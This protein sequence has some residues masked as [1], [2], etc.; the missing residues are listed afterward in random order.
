[1]EE[2]GQLGDGLAER[3]QARS[4]APGG[5]CPVTIPLPPQAAFALAALEEAGFEAWCV[6]DGR[7]S[8]RERVSCDV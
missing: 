8:C 3:G 7:A 1:M 2:P 4:A 5:P 6:G